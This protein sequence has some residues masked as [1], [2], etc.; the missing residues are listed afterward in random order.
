MKLM[1]H[2][3]ALFLLFSYSLPRDV[4]SHD[5]KREGAWLPLCLGVGSL[6]IAPSG[7]RLAHVVRSARRGVG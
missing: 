3:V 6:P 1:S 5:K 4:L 7:M 2:Q